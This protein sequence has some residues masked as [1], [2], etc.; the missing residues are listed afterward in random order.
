[1]MR[2]STAAKVQKSIFALRIFASTFGIALIFMYT[3][4]I[5]ATNITMNPSWAPHPPIY[6]FL[7]TSMVFALGLVSVS[8]LDIIMPPPAW[9]MKHATSIQTKILVSQA[10]LM[11]QMDWSVME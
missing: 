11:R 9:T 1:M 2:T 5:M 3:L 8:V 6:T 4:T 7:P 10:A